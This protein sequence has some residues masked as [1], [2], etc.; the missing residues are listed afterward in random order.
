MSYQ[1][2]VGLIIS[3]IFIFIFILLLLL[4][5]LFLFLL[6]LLNLKKTIIIIEK[7]HKFDLKGQIKNYKNLG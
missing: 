6:L 3:I 7:T 1:R 2:N 5:V 4:L